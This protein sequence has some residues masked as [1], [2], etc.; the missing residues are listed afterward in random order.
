MTLKRKVR[1]GDIFYANLNPIIGSEQD[2]IRP[3]LVIQNNVGNT[4]SST[5]II[6]VITTQ[7]K[8]YIPT[9]VRLSYYPRLE[10][11]TVLLEQIRTIDEKR[12]MNFVTHITESDL[13]K[14]ETAILT[15]FGIHNDILSVQ[16]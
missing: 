12:L 16:S 1:K 11:S 10:N 9:H 8:P 2:G 6:A 4:H 3:V 15:S 5:T 13:K 14:I 7:N